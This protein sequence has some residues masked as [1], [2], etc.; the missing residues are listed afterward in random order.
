MSL[1]VDDLSQDDRGSG[2]VRPRL[3]RHPLDP[4]SLVAGLLAVGVALLALLSIDVDADVVLPA[5]LLLAGAAGLL[6]AARRTR[7]AP[8]N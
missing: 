4:V 5:R 2:S 7:G 8:G 3:G 1:P 6:S